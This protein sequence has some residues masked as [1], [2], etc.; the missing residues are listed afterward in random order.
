MEIPPISELPPIERLVGDADEPDDLKASAYAEVEPRL[1]EDLLP[2]LE[3]VRPIGFGSMAGVYL[4]REVLL[5]RLVAIKVLGPHVAR[6]QKARARFE[7]EAQSAARIAHP[8]VV[9]VYRAGTLS[10]ATPYLVMRYI[11]GTTMEERLQG[12]GPLDLDTGVEIISQMAAALAAAHHL[13]I[14]HRDV[15]PANILYEEQTGRAFLSD[16]GLVSILA[17]GDDSPEKITT[18]GH[19]V[20]EM[21]YSSPEELRGEEAGERADIYTLGLTAY[22]LLSGEGPYGTPGRL[23]VVAGHLQMEPAPLRSLVEGST[24]ELDDLLLRCLSKQPAT[25][26]AAADV[27]RQLGG[28][29][30]SSLHIPGT[31]DP[32]EMTAPVEVTASDDDTADEVP[33]DARFLFT[34]LGSTD[35]RSTSGVALSS[36]LS[37]PK[38]VALLSY[39]GL[40]ARDGFVRRDTLMAMFWP[41]ATTEK[42]R[43]SLRQSVYVLRRAF[44]PNVVVSRGDDELGIAGGHVTIDVTEFEALAADGEFERAMAV[45]A[46]DFLPGFYVPDAADFEYWLH[47]ERQRLRELAGQAAWS[48][49]VQTER[50][51][52]R[53]AAASWGRRA[54]DLAPFDES[55]QRE[56]VVLLER[57]GDR[58]GAILAYDQFASRLRAEYEMEPAPETRDLA[59]KIRSGQ[60]D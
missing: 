53:T 59:E 40:G 9:T 54:A 1:R 60:A 12:V 21:R 20:G 38:R 51:G 42:A 11:R 33:D 44:G 13:G 35:L 27:A 25:R 45:Y 4:A 22:E 46:G 26:P 3:I 52:D 19:I 28:R 2:D 18:Q 10:D 43:H 32:V 36:V 29:R 8:N 37:Q 16:F 24:T 30:L 50:A 6:V 55:L 5:R 23:N 56:L 39:L 41:A 48:M 14:V 49:A 47:S 17:S 7:R 57:L 58:V 31:D 15:K 34:T